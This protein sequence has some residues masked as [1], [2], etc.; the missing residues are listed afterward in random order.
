MRVPNHFG[1]DLLC[2]FNFNEKFFCTKQ[3]YLSFS[4]N[5][6]NFSG[7]GISSK[8]EIIIKSLSSHSLSPLTN[9]FL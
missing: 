3:A 1:S 4:P 5:S 2:R 8:S 7:L 6:D 9:A